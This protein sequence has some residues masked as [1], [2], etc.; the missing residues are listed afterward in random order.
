MECLLCKWPV[1]T[2][3]RTLTQAWQVREVFLEEAT[4]N[5]GEWDSVRM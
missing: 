4:S 2:Q 1:E 5:L 3:K